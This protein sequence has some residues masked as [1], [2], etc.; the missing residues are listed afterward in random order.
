MARRHSVESSFQPFFVAATIAAH[1][2]HRRSGFRLRDARF[3][4]E[5][6]SNWMKATSGEAT[7]PIQNIQV[8]RYLSALEKKG[9]LKSSGAGQRTRYRLT[10]SGITGLLG[11]LVGRP[12]YLPLEH[13]YFVFFFLK[14]YGTLLDRWIQE[15]EQLVGRS[16]SVEMKFLRDPTPVVQNQL[17]YLEK[18][19]ET[20]AARIEDALG[21]AKLGESVL[22]KGGKLEDAVMQVHKKFPYDLT[23]QKPLPDLMRDIPN[24][25]RQ[26]ELTTGMRQRAEVL[27]RPMHAYLENHRKA[28]KA[29]LDTL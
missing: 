11:E 10:R 18:E 20:L 21:A 23:M 3:I 24:E 28:L 9:F 27:W 14:S 22:S 6:F 7:L 8:S 25:L 1:F 2:N 15:D 16:L 5:L 19:S 12:Y 29:L 13:F 26:W 4:I 17:R